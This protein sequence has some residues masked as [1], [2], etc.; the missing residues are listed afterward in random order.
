MIIHKYLEMKYCIL[1]QPTNQETTH[2]GKIEII[3]DKWKKNHHTKNLENEA[4]A[5]IRR[6]VIDANI[7]K[8]KSQMGCGSYM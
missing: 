1:Y 5:V 4:K 6:D 2:K 7:K 3:W 8:D